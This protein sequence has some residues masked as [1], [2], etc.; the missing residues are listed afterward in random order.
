[1]LIYPGVYSH[2]LYPR[3]PHC[4]R[5]STLS[6]WHNVCTEP[7]VPSVDSKLSHNTC[8]TQHGGVLQ[9]TCTRPCLGCLCSVQ[10][11]LLFQNCDLLL[12]GSTDEQHGRPG[13]YTCLDVCTWIC[14]ARVHL[15]LYRY[16]HAYKVNH[17]TPI[18]KCVGYIYIY[19]FVYIIYSK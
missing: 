2:A 7:Q 16:M 17:I 8:R 11:Q 18:Y 4:T 10:T 6:K 13:V 15:Y 19:M 5:S 1:M 14:K 9:H 3:I 12:V